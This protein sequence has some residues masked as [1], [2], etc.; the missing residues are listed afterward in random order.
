LAS[1]VPHA[2]G[3][4]VP[5]ESSQHADERARRLRLLQDA[6]GLPMD[7]LLPTVGRRLDALCEL[8]VARAAA[9]DDAYR[10][11]I[12]EGHL[13]HYR[14][15]VAFVRRHAVEWQPRKA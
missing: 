1:F 2:D 8:L 6:Y 15:E 3:S 13:D 11:L 14:R 9:G 5:Y 12:A 7:D 10:R 4:T